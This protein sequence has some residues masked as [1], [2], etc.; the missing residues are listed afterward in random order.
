M[1]QKLDNMLILILRSTLLGAASGLLLSLALSHFSWLV[2]LGFIPV[3]IDL[4]ALKSKQILA[5]VSG[6]VFGAVLG[7]ITFSW[8]LPAGRP[9]EWI[10]NLV[11][12]GITGAL[13][14]WFVWR[15]VD[16][17]MLGRRGDG[18]NRLEPMLS[19]DSNRRHAWNVSSEHL[20]VS[21]LVALAWAFLEW[22][23]GLLVPGWNCVGVALGENILLQTTKV[24]GPSFLSFLVVFGNVI[25][26]AAIRRIILE[27]GRMTWASRFDVTVSLA[28]F[29]LAALACFF[30]L[31]PAASTPSRK[32]AAVMSKRGDAMALT[33]LSK[34]AF[35]DNTDLSLWPNVHLSGKDDPKLE[36][37]NPNTGLLI[38]LTTAQNKHVSMYRVSLP[39]EVRDVLVMP[40]K[41]GYFIPFAKEFHRNLAPFMFKDTSWLA[42]LNWEGGSLPLL[43]AAAKHGVQVFIEFFDAPRVGQ[44][45]TKQLMQNMRI[46]SVA[47]GRPLIFSANRLGVFMVNTTGRTTVAQSGQALA[48]I[49][50][51]I[52]LPMPQG[53]TLYNQYGDWFP[54]ACGMLIIS[55]AFMTRLAVTGKS[56]GIKP[57]G[58]QSRKR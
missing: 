53:G 42:L 51:T 27:P 31:K 28:L 45:G 19:S 9:I 36:S 24:F 57:T 41:N 10:T 18:K 47:L 6:L 21:L 15:F 34:K 4:L 22:G 44:T 54:I 48:S 40:S 23:R 5:P 14:A 33:E 8:L 7:G 20:K 1:E 58:T 38:G 17:P 32:M 2:W 35:R 43:Q 25:I 11:S 37:G 3:L 13:W 55:F 46:W 52:D 12:F 26:L 39:T 49:Q 29:L 56:S 50:A 30:S 16:L